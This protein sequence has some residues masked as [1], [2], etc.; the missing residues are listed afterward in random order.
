[1]GKPHVQRATVMRADR[2]PNTFGRRALGLVRRCEAGIN[3]RLQPVE[4]ASG[5]VPF[6][7]PAA[8]DGWYGDF[9]EGGDLWQN[10]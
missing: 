9:L 7:V 5:M 10:V 3:W 6:E 8:S 4:P 1:M 2:R